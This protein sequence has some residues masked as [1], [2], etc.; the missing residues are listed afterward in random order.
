[1]SPLSAT[2]FDKAF[3]QSGAYIQQQPTLAMAEATGLAEAT[4]LGCPGSDAAAVA[5]LRALP[6]ATARTAGPSGGYSPIIDNYVLLESTWSAFAAGRFLKVPI[7]TGSSHYE[8]NLYAKAFTT[9]PLTADNYATTLASQLKGAPSAIDITRLYPAGAFSTPTRAF[10][11]AHSDY[12]FFCGMV[13]D[14]QNIARYDPDS[15]SYQFAEQNP[16]QQVADSDPGRY[17]GPVLPWF[18]PWGDYHVSDTFYWFD[19]FTDAE[20]TASNVALSTSMRANLSNFARTGNPNGQGLVAW[21]RA[22]AS[23]LTVLDLATPIVADSHAASDHRCS[24]WATMP[25]STTLR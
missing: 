17:P 18:G 20:R 2:L 1:M 5:C 11:A 7:V 22:S 14:A 8:L 9:A 6:V 10:L 25:P 13:S 16:V 24:Y 4:K 3:V 23:G 19:M 21:P 15:W 12:T